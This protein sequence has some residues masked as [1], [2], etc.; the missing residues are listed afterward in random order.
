MFVL[1]KLLVRGVKLIENCIFVGNIKVISPKDRLRV[2]KE[3]PKI[4][5]MVVPGRPLTTKK[6]TTTL[7][8]DALSKG[9]VD[10]ELTMG[11]KG[12]LSSH[13]IQ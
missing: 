9:L 1:D 10:E 6:S 5:C 13:C 11:G 12:I 2:L 4:H 8:C 3:G 7:G